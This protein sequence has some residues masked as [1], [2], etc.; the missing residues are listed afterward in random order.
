MAKKLV[1]YFRAAVFDQ[2]PAASE[3]RKFL[4]RKLPDYMVLSA[5]VALEKLPLTPNGKI[6]QRA[7]PRRLWIRKETVRLGPHGTVKT[8]AHVWSVVLNLEGIGVHDDFFELGGHSLL[9]FDNATSL[10]SQSSSM[11]PDRPRPERLTHLRY[12]T[13]KKSCYEVLAASCN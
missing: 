3:L 8:V 2:P 10:R 7:Y 11:A 12:P 4:R 13:A 6:D 5:F 9:L 1:A